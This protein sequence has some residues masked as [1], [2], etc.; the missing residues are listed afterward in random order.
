MAYLYLS[1]AL[2][3][4]WIGGYFWL[5]AI[6]S[7]FNH[8]RANYLGEV[9]YGLFIGYAAVQGVMLGYNELFGTVDFLPIISLLTLT[10]LAGIAISAKTRPLNSA[11][12][13]TTVSGVTEGQKYK[14]LLFWLFTAW[15][16][17]HL[18]FA[19]IE[20]LHLPVFPW[21]AWLNWM[22]RAKAWFYAGH[23]FV[24]DHPSDWLNGA[25]DALYN[26][27]GN[28]YP[29][30]SPILALWAATALGYW[31]ET[32][33][34]MPVLLCG[35]AMGLAMYGQCVEF[36]LEKWLSA[37][38][39]YLLLSIPLVG[40]HLALAGG[41]DIWMAG[42]SGLGFVA[43][44][45]GI[46]RDR[47]YQTLL[48]L[49]MTAMGIAIKLEGAVWFLAALMTLLIAIRPRLTFTCLALA[50]ALMALGWLTGL[51]YF[52]LPLLGGV[53]VTEGRIHIPLLGSYQ[54]QTF[55]LWDDY[56]TNFF[57]NGTWHLLWTLIILS[58]FTMWLIPA[59]IFRR[60]NIAFY[61]V[62]M[63]TQLII[64]KGSQS[65]QWAEDWTAINRLPLH[66][67]PPLIF[68]IAILV[69]LLLKRDTGTKN[70]RLTFTAPILGLIIT[71]GVATAYLAI[72]YPSSAG[73]KPHKFNAEDMS[74]VVGSGRLADGV[75]VVD[76]FDD[77][78]A[79]LSSGPV[80]LDTEQLG[81]LRVETQ[82]P[83][84]GSA[85]FFWRSANRRNAINGTTFS[86][87]GVRWINLDDL[88]GWQGRVKEIGLLFHSDEDK[89]VGFHGLELSPNS[90]SLNI[91]KL[92]NDWSETELWKLKSPNWLEAGATP[93]SISLP[94]LMTAW[95]I[96]TLLLAVAMRRWNCSV[97]VSVILCSFAAWS[98]L[99][100]RWTANSFV[101]AATTIRDYPLIAA[102]HLNMQN[103]KQTRE[104][105]DAAR[106]EIGSSNARTIIMSEDETMDFQMLRAKYHALP[107]AAIVH[108]GPL[109][110][111]PVKLGDY[112]LVLSKRY[113]VNKNRADPGY[114]PAVAAD[115]AKVIEQR[116]GLSATP[117]WDKQ[118]GFLIEIDHQSKPRQS[119]N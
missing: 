33:V 102:A 56:L 90:L 97:Y 71:L 39:A 7:R 96:I 12:D 92:K 89:P 34:N 14:R 41:A 76:N 107:A 87:R 111:A 16:A 112:L 3:L 44:L 29:T 72:T 10:A 116:H 17:L 53:G 88:P 1:V 106:R 75:R 47:K 83:N 66:F 49:G 48:G 38:A 77:N 85:T 19:A 105:V 82:G 55:D 9:G 73:S 86:G 35:V 46:I 61:A 42:F 99:D 31:S 43:L 67:A 94:V 91:R 37:L 54:L 4:P 45:H 40:T 69:Q 25:G 68:S 93:T 51:T 13:V 115:Y 113:L 58:A 28:H 114:E 26:V 2:F 108:E 65:G 117:L 118:E 63:V 95:V 81:M 109:E 80:R 79:V 23:I 104:L 57:M 20:I 64:F 119:H 11:V 110:N 30:F 103:D 60:T 74:I 78:V 62:L 18:I 70:F 100:L 52:E 5:A 59:G 36:G 24:L 22:Y 6:A 32:L 8:D 27:V 50:T 21:D 98:L 101:Q 15:A 84:Q